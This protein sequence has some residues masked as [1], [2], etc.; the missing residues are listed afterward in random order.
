MMMITVQN[1]GSKTS[2]IRKETRFK[3]SETALGCSC[4]HP[5]IS[6]SKHKKR[7][8]HEMYSE[9]LLEVL[10]PK[11]IG[12]RMQSGIMGKIGNGYTSFLQIEK[13]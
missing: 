3:Q 9:I 7:D 1:M 2:G 11:A 5:A 12:R 13:K 4:C 8:F 10:L 6:Q